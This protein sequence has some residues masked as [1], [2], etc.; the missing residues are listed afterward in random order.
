MA[1]R[2][3]VRAGGRIWIVLDGSGLV[4]AGRAGRADRGGQRGE[5][6]EG[7]AEWGG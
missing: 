2:G 3:R 1:R 4:W 5:G 7:R 6:G